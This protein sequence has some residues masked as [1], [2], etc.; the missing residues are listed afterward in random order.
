MCRISLIST[1]LVAGSFLAGSSAAWAPA[2]NPAVDAIFA[3]L[4][5]PGSPGC[6]L[7]VYRDGRIIYAKGYG[8]ANIEENVPITPQTIF[9][10]GSISKQFTAASILLL[11]KQGRLRL[12]D[13]V[14]KYIPELPDYSQGRQ[15]ITILHLLNHTSGLRDYVSLFLLSGIHYDNVT[16]DD[17]ALGIIVRQKGLN[18]P[19]GSDWKYT[20]SGYL[21]LS[22]IVKRVSGKTLKDFAAKNIFQPLGMMHTQFRNDHTSLIPNRALAYE[23]GEDGTYKL[24]VSYGEENGDGMVHTSVEDLQRWDENFYA[25][26]IGGKDLL[27]EM[28]ERGKLNDG[29]PLK[30]A[31]GLFLRNYRGLSTIWHS[32]LSAG[33]QSY[34]IR[35][36]EHHFS[37]AC[38]CN[39]LLF[40]TQRSHRVA[41]LYLGS[42]M[43]PGEVDFA[44]A[45]PETKTSAS[46]S[47]EQLPV[48]S[49]DY[50]NSKNEDVL[51]VTERDGT[52]WLDF[53]G[54]RRSLRAL[55]AT[56]FEPLRYFLQ[57][58]LKF[59]PA[60]N[61]TPRKL[62]VER[63]MDVRTH[64]RT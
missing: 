47:T 38:L 54:V 25:G 48:W 32:G 19:P 51:R 60:Q 26:Q 10:V 24:S 7:G 42:V 4:T 1:C 49:G 3:D 12:D 35:F 20:G 33:Y 40:P 62:I 44:T 30:Y 22:L 58:R 31:K 45:G 11:E 13:D 46:I 36:P 6:A 17:D 15:P 21:L 50:R 2:A 64:L 59:E 57:I 9:D 61:A 28:Q 55:S 5:R 56:E 43:R 34:L 29:R 39:G 63:E 52:L 41:N 18:F 53:D 14:R 37:I 8:L 16:T 27:A 23:Q